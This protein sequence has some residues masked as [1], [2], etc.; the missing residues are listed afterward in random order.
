MMINVCVYES[1]V[2]LHH[3]SKI[4]RSSMA[5]LLP[6]SSPMNLLVL[7]ESESS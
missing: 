2:V 5:V 6:S 3:V 7:H 4:S 1:Q